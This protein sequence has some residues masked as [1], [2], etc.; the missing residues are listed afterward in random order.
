M[1]EMDMLSPELLQQTVF[2]PGVVGGGDTLRRF[3]APVAAKPQRNS[4]GSNGAGYH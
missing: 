4:G 2:R 1:A 3:V